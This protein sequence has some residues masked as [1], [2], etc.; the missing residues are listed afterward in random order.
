MAPAR[1]AWRHAEFRRGFIEMVPTALGIGAWGLITGV[2]MGKSGLPP[3]LM[4][5][6]ALVVFAGSAQLAVLPLM[7]SG[8]PVWVVWATAA[9]V[10]LRFVIFSA[11][12]RPYIVHLPF[13][14]RVRM[15]YFTAD[16]N[17]ALF[18]RRFPEPRPAPEPVSPPEP[19]VLPEPLTPPPPPSAPVSLLAAEHPI[20][21]HTTAQS[22]THDSRMGSSLP[23]NPGVRHPARHAAARQSSFSDGFRAKTPPS[24]LRSRPRKRSGPRS[25]V[26]V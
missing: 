19:E 9:C 1:P 21:R 4:V 8:A 23:S 7:A 17:T 12:W 6:M 13:Q 24:A 25:V 11:V 5:L 22:G 10:N 14:Q 2:A 18:T 26:Q 20:D 3:A 16:L 15:A